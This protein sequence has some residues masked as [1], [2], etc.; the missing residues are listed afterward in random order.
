MRFFRIIK[1][2]WRRE[3]GLRL[4]KILNNTLDPCACSNEVVGGLVPLLKEVRDQIHLILPFFEAG[5]VGNFV[6]EELLVRRLDLS[7]WLTWLQMCS[8]L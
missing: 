8:K 1:P 6:P 7:E 4:Q 3:S 5:I 2:S